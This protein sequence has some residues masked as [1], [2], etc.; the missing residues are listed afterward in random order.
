MLI[1]KPEPAVRRTEMLRRLT[2]ARFPPEDP[3]PQTVL[4]AFNAMLT[5]GLAATA[6]TV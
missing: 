2:G 5:V 6:T 4:S 1:A 3:H